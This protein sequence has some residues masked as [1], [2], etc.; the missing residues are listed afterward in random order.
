MPSCATK[1]HIEFKC[2]TSWQKGAS[3]DP[4]VRAHLRSC[5]H[6]SF[7][8][9]F[10]IYETRDNSLQWKRTLSAGFF[11]QP[12]IYFHRRPFLS[13]KAL[14]FDGRTDAQ[15]LGYIIYRDGHSMEPPIFRP[16]WGLMR[17][18][19]V[20]SPR[21]QNICYRVSVAFPVSK[22]S[23]SLG[24]SLLNYMPILSFA[25]TFFFTWHSS[26]QRKESKCR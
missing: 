16:G 18:I 15:R 10:A 8:S 20:V 2:H 5:A 24:K 21:Q 3:K 9:R 23:F 14:C 4:E 6:W 1:S 19:D 17:A 25:Y 12:R 7:Q 13:R 11:F 26:C 22:G